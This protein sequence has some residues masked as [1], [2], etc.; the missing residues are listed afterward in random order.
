MPKSLK[1]AYVLPAVQVIAAIV[2]L[3][4]GDAISVRIG[5]IEFMGGIRFLCYAINAPA[6]VTR[7]LEG[8]YAPVRW[9][10]EHVLP[11]PLH[12]DNILF[13][14]CVYILWFLIGRSIDDHKKQHA[15]LSGFKLATRLSLDA[16]LLIWAVILFR[17][18]WFTFNTIDD[19]FVRFSGWMIDGAITMAWSVALTLLS[20]LHI[21]RSLIRACDFA[22]PSQGEV[23]L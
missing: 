17:Q 3:Q 21:L 7:W 16:L 6:L 15:S 22:P 2:M 10:P 5:I 11:G 19:Q 9:M 14:V 1:L 4:W 18:G 20:A 23:H 13:L 8:H 12:T